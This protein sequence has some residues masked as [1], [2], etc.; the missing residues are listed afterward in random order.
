MSINSIQK[1]PTIQLSENS[2]NNRLGRTSPPLAQIP[3]VLITGSRSCPQ[4]VDDIGHLISEFFNKIITWV[5]NLFGMNPAPTSPLI[6][7]PAQHAHQI[8]HPNKL[9]A[10]NQLLQGHNMSNDR[11]SAQ[12]FSLSDTQSI[13][14]LPLFSPTPPLI[15]SINGPFCYDCSTSDTVHW[16]A[17]F[18]DTNVFGFSDGPLMAQDELQVLEH[19]GLAHVKHAFPID[20]RTLE[21]YDVALFQNVPR[22]GALDTSTPLANGQTLYGNYFATATTNEIH[23]R[24]TRFSSPSL[25]NI[26]AIAAPR[27]PSSWNSLP[28]RREDLAKLFFTSYNAFRSIKNVNEV[29]K[30]VIHTGNWGAGA[31]GNDAKTAQL[32][33]LAAAE[34]AGIDEVRMHPMSHANAFHAAKQLFAQMKIQLPQMTSGQFLDH[35]T[36]NATNYDLRYR[37]GNGT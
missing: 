13:E 4:W 27:I 19:P 26:F 6:L 15:T 29:K 14:T 32:I 3:D 20:L 11:I 37:L 17:N 24:L 8:F 30:V 5:S 33:Q 23:S 16:T 34:L 21:M 2:Q 10:Y 7:C 31:F 35:L 25:S 36:A 12:K 1:S 22:L 18:A 28:Y 9:F